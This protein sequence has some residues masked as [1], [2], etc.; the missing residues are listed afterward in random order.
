M[1]AY[2]KGKVLKAAKEDLDKKVAVKK[3]KKKKMTRGEERK[4]V[5]RDGHFPPFFIS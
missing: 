5:S 3:K 2:L 4:S 1:K